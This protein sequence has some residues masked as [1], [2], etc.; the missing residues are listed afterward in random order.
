MDSRH[1]V[2]PELAP[3]LEA[4]PAFELSAETLPLI[5][6]RTLPRPP[7]PP[8]DVRFDR[9][10][11]P[12]RDG[13]PPVP[14][15]IYRANGV[16]GPLPCILH[17]HGGGYVAGAAGEL[18]DI[19]RSLAAA[20]RCAIVSVEYRLAPETAFPGNVEDAYAGLAW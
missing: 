13:A 7:A 3:L 8:V 14:L 16:E 17:L 9:A 20:L 11:A 12:G 4:W 5:R 6:S 10:E 19:H 1:L 18:E 2:D 15:W